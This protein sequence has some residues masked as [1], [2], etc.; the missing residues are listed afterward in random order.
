M[1]TSYD[2]VSS[3]SVQVASC[4]VRAVVVTVSPCY[5]LFHAEC[6]AQP[7]QPTK[8]FTACSCRLLVELHHPLVPL[9]PTTPGPTPPHQVRPPA[10]LFPPPKKPPLNPTLSHHAATLVVPCSDT[11]PV[12]VVKVLLPDLGTETARPGDRR[13]KRPGSGSHTRTFK[14][15][16]FWAE[17]G[18]AQ[19]RMRANS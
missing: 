11:A 18:T 14:G 8:T 6:F 16:R 9:D 1:T 13:A 12:P 3:R 4:F 5:K 2:F 19:M 10:P 7:S 15:S 17:F